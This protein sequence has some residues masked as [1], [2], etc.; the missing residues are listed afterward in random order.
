M[1]VESRAE[2]GKTLREGNSRGSNRSADP[3][4]RTSRVA[5][6]PPTYELANRSGKKDDV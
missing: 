3:C 5:Y 6:G 4:S 2:L 1:R